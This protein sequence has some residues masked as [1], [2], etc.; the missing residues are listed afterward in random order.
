MN[1][2]D[3]GSKTPRRYEG[4]PAERIRAA[5]T[6]VPCGLPSE[7]RTALIEQGVAALM[8]NSPDWPQSA[9]RREYQKAPRNE[10]AKGQLTKI[11]KALD[12]VEALLASDD[13]EQDAIYAL[14]EVGL[15]SNDEPSDPA[16][17]VRCLVKRANSALAMFNPKGYEKT[18]DPVKLVLIADKYF[19]SLAVGHRTRR[20]DLTNLVQEIFNAVGV[21]S[22]VASAMVLA[23][24]PTY[25]RPRKQNSS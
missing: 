15:I 25:K 1:D 17:A 2:D 6:E 16:A 5:L 12:A 18:D 21:T 4:K 10:K 22:N 14:S 9:V 8:F 11:V 3:A 23:L 13:L 24:P 20:I 7:E 19:T